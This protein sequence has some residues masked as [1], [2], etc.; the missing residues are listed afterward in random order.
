[1]APITLLAI[2]YIILCAEESFYRMLILF[3]YFLSETT[4]RLVEIEKFQDKEMF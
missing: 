2:Y 4:F 1:M 3:Y